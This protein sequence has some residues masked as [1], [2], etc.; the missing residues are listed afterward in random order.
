MFFLTI[1]FSITPAKAAFSSF[2]IPG[3]GDY[4]MGD[5]KRGICFMAAEA[6]IWLTYFDS[7]AEEDKKDRISR[8]FAALYASCN[9]GN[10][11]EDYFN[12]M[13]DFLTNVD[14]NEMIKE[15]ARNE[16]PDTSDAEVMVDRIQLR[17]EYIEA[18]S[19]T[20]PDAWDWRSLEIEDRYRDMRRDKRGLHQKATNMIGLAVA[21]RAVSFLTTYFF[22]SRVSLEIK[23]KEIEMGFRF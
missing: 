23:D 10:E 18:N 11:D 12:A 4:L 21:N 20:G 22:G 6:A 15:K 14:Y 16:Y 5:K 2:V 1:L 19:Y 3:S 7:K 8:N 13:E 9:R 17:K